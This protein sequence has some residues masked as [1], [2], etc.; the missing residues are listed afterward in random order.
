MTSFTCSGPS[1][2]SRPQK[3]LGA[4]SS[5]AAAALAASVSPPADTTTSAAGKRSARMP[6]P[7]RRISAGETPRFTSCA[8]VRVGTTKRRRTSRRMVVTGRN[9]PMAA[10]TP[11]DWW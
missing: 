1:R 10:I 4:P 11:S 2:R 9:R 3:M 6:K 7:S 5:F 8:S